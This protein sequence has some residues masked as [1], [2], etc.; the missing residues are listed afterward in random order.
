M[1]APAVLTPIPNV[2]LY[3]LRH[4][5]PLLNHFRPHRRDAFGLILTSR[6]PSCVAPIYP[7]FSPVVHPSHRPA[8]HA[9]RFAFAICSHGFMNAV[10]G[11]RSFQLFLDVSLCCIGFVFRYPLG[12]NC[13][14]EEYG[15]TSSTCPQIS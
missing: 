11:P 10:R 9:P 13:L 3:S 12:I 8:S 7:T 1:S 2:C 4:L 14:F 5:P 15:L 6:R